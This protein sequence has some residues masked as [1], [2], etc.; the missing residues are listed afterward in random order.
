MPE[1][2]QS[3][4]CG[5]MDLATLPP[6]KF[7]LDT[8]RCIQGI[9]W[10]AVNQPGITQFYIGVVFFFADKRHL[11]DWGRPISG[12]QYI[13]TEHGPAPFTIYELLKSDS[14]APD[15]IAKALNA[16][17]RTVTH[18]NRIQ[19]FSVEEKP[20]YPALSRT[21]REYLLEALQTYGKMSYD[22]L[23]RHY[24]GDP[25]YAA[26]SELA[27]VNNELDVRLWF[28]DD[29]AFLEEIFETAPVRRRT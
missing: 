9:Q 28:K 26:A 16:R 5:E 22:E 10:L 29:P 19:I 2:A 11:M 7:R 3:S 18:E 14:G 4:E 8:D 17:L 15:E 13:A 24:A 20:S 1:Q 25:A 27:G 23:L 6:I 12:D 21:D